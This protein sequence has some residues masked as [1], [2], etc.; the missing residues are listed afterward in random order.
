MFALTSPHQSGVAHGRCLY[1]DSYVAVISSGSIF[2][3]AAFLYG[4]TPV[5][6]RAGDQLD[7]V[8]H[9]AIISSSGDLVSDQVLLSLAKRNPGMNPASSVAVNGRHLGT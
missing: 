9:L 5:N 8:S 3:R 4:R 7:G 2:C 1:P 6:K